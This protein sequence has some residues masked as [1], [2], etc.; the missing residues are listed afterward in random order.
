MKETMELILKYKNIID[1]KNQISFQT[2]GANDFIKVS[3]LLMETLRKEE[4][5]LEYKE[6][7]FDM[8]QYP[9]SIYCSKLYPKH[10]YNKFANSDKSLYKKLLSYT[11][12]QMI[13]LNTHNLDKIVINNDINTIPDISCNTVFNNKLLAIKN[14]NKHYFKE[15]YLEAS[16][17]F[18]L[19]CLELNKLNSIETTEF[20]TNFHTLFSSYKT[21]HF[22][23]KM[24]NNLYSLLDT[25]LR[26]EIC[27]IISF[28]LSSEDNLYIQFKEEFGMFEIA[29]KFKNSKY[30]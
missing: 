22:K 5:F 17:Y 16:N 3:K 15:L 12:E 19:Y 28:A 21:Y 18:K 9:I 27:S 8:V 29:Y 25:S 4:I 1:S 13:Y 20:I 14:Y 26:K 10:F 23:L 2:D 7:L 30:N 24:I 6:L 11:I